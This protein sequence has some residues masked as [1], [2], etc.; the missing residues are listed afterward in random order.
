MILL[1]FGRKKE[2]HE[3]KG[4]HSQEIVAVPPDKTNH[5]FALPN[6]CTKKWL[7]I[8][9]TMIE[10]RFFFAL[11]FSVSVHYENNFFN[12]PFNV[13]A[14]AREEPRSTDCCVCHYRSR[15]FL[16]MTFQRRRKKGRG[17]KRR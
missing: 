13:Q 7:T 11:F 8:L 10:I 4:K 16:R 2:E 12:K 6:D 14:Q 3:R 1:L 17:K 15:P 5:S 9:K